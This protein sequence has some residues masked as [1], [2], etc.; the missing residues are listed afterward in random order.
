MKKLV[1]ALQFLYHVRT[2]LFR[3]GMQSFFIH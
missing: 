3:L 1:K 2:N